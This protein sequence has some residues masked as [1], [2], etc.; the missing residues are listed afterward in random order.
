MLYSAHIHTERA[1][2]KKKL[3]KGGRGKREGFMIANHMGDG[4]RESPPLQKK[5]EKCR[6]ENK[7]GR[8]LECKNS[9]S[10]TGASVTGLVGDRHHSCAVETWSSVSRS[11]PTPIFLSCATTSG[12]PKS[13]RNGVAVAVP[14]TITQQYGAFEIMI[15]C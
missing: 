13:A 6:K 10:R 2:G 9:F 5:K 4:I 1:E 8:S 14:R 3:K 7:V 11:S 15:S 12:G